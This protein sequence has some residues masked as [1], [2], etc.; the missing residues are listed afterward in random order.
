MIVKDCSGHYIKIADAVDGS[1]D[2]CF[3]TYSNIASHRWLPA[4][5]ARKMAEHILRI[6]QSQPTAA[7]E[8]EG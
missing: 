4:N 5:E 6:T 3:E 1:G 8:G 2:I 7:G